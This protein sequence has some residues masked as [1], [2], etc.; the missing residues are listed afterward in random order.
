MFQ[1]LLSFQMMNYYQLTHGLEEVNSEEEE[2]SEKRD[3]VQTK[4]EEEEM[5]RRN[6]GSKSR[7]GG[8]GGEGQQGLAGL[9]LALGGSLAQDTISD[10]MRE[11]ERNCVRG[12]G[13]GRRGGEGTDQ[14]G[15]AGG[16]GGGGG[17]GGGGG[18]GG[19]GGV[20]L[21]KKPGSG[22]PGSGGSI[23]RRASQR[24]SRIL[25]GHQSPIIN[26][27]SPSQQCTAN[28]LSL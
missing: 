16:G 19:G 7:A 23:G 8:G 14:R 6:A 17:V 20:V 28:Q 9:E 3:T 15:G 26:H 11:R 21:R 5:F 25:E 27:Q 2:D 10:F 4:R 24:F 12:G 18:D 1:T 22:H 13:G